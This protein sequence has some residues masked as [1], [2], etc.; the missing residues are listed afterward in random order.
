MDQD[1][2]PEELSTVQA[3]GNTADTSHAP[4]INPPPRPPSPRRDHRTLPQSPSL[5]IQLR[6]D[7]LPQMYGPFPLRFPHLPPYPTRAARTN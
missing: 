7:D 1:G 6:Q 4:G 3:S 2:P 5:Q